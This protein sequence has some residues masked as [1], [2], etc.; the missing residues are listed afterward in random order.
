MVQPPGPFPPQPCDVSSMNFPSIATL[1]ACAACLSFAPVPANPSP[2]PDDC[3]YV[4]SSITVSGA[5][6][7]STSCSNCCRHLDL[8]MSVPTCSGG[9][10]FQNCAT[11]NFYYQA[12]YRYCTGAPPYDCIYISTM[13]CSHFAV[14]GFASVICPTPP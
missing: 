11:Q 6:M 5:C 1:A 9:N 14:G 8:G 3:L 2:A 12:E 10:H 13:P 7:Q 4:Q